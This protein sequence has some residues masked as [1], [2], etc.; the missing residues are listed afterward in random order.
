MIDYTVKKSELSVEG[1]FRHPAF[2]L[3]SPKSD[4]HKTVTTFLSDFYAIQSRDIRITQDTDPL[5][6]AEVTYE[7]RPFNGFARVSIERAQLVLFSPHTVNSE[8]IANLSLA[9]LNG[10]DKEV[11]DSPYASF[12]IQIGFHAELH[13][14]AP[15]VYT[16][17]YVSSTSK[18]LD[19]IVGNSITYYLGQEESRIHSSV[20][21][22]MSGE[23]SEC[24]FVRMALR[25]DGEK[26]VISDLPDAVLK[27]YNQLLSLIGLDSDS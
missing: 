5:S 18:D 12:L 6:N 13:D 9:L 26:I 23:F 16:K 2:A 27:H 21:L 14:I 17:K 8:N 11:N 20:T 25:Y 3:L 1:Y 4:L 22:D 7:L 10:V 19:S 24:V 15:S